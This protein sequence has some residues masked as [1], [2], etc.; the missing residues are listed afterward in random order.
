MVVF[1]QSHAPMHDLAMNYPKVIRDMLAA[2]SMTQAEFARRVKVTQP[3]VSR[4]L[5]GSQ[6]PEIDQHE[7]I[8]AE[9]ARIG[10]DDLIARAAALPDDDEAP[11][12]VPV[13]GWVGASAEAEYYP[14][15]TRLDM[16][17]TIAGATPKTIALEIRGTSLGDW[18][19]RWFV[20]IDDERKP[21]APELV[22]QP[23]V[24]WLADGRVLVKR[25][26]RGK[27]GLFDLFSNRD[28]VAPIR[29]VAVEYASKIKHIGSR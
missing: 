18:F 15:E 28:G 27:N 20:Y 7:R 16:A 21:P 26:Q 13:K 1:E 22:G 10:L 4:W 11:A 12:G 24:V 14:T 29:N 23:C 6:K 9:A 3:T 25:L 19:D 8:A 2:S 5:N 17:P